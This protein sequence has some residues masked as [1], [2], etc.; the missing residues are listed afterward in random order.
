MAKQRA[1]SPSR[2]PAPAP[3]FYGSPE[4]CGD[5]RTRT[6]PVSCYAHWEHD[7]ARDCL[8]L[9]KPPRQLWR[10]DRCVMLDM[11][12]GVGNVPWE[13]RADFRGDYPREPALGRRLRGTPAPPDP[14]Q[15]AIVAELWPSEAENLAAV[16]ESEQTSLRELPGLRRLLAVMAE[17]ASVGEPSLDDDD[18]G[19]LWM[20]TASRRHE[21]RFLRARVRGLREVGDKLLA[22]TP[23]LD[24]QAGLDRGA[25]LLADWASKYGPRR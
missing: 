4:C 8:M 16:M 5:C 25:R 23:A 18:D 22:L 12:Y 21:R 13:R 20:P 6:R 14:D 7:V 1:A 10:C 3:P 15:L 11:A 17:V 24:E 9:D 2:K 19:D